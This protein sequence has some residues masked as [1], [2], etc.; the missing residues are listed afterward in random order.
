MRQYQGWLIKMKNE[1]KKKEEEE[2]F[3]S[4]LIA[5]KFFWGTMCDKCV[6]FL[7]M[8]DDAER[9]FLVFT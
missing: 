1:K 8:V 4:C 3:A 9:F 5:Y 2:A 6:I 7:A